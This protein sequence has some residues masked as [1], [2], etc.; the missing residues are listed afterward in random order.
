VLSRV[1]AEVFAIE[2]HASLA[3]AA[4]RRL[5]DLGID[6][7][8]VMEGDGSLGWPEHA[9]F[10]GILVSAGATEVPPALRL[11]LA[12]GGRMVIP[13]GPQGVPKELL[14]LRSVN[15][16]VVERSLGPVRFV[17][18][19]GA[20]SARRGA[21]PT[22]RPGARPR[23]PRMVDVVRAKAES[24]EE[25]ARD[26]HARPDRARCGL[27]RQFDEWI[28]LDHTSAVT[29]LAAGPDAE[30]PDGKALDTFPFAV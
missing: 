9:P 19:I 12:P 23:A 27:P 5:R 24:L 25:V 20:P 6:N 10:E 22:P 30:L 29:P 28:F 16:D 21:G 14:L 15:G 8:R 7:V 17:P 4:E 3:G 13:V 11:Q 18:L 1:C 26:P 2:R